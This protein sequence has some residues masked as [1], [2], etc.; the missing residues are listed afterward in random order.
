M[1]MDQEICRRLWKV[2]HA[3]VRRKNAT[4]PCATLDEQA[5]PQDQTACFPGRDEL[6]ET[7]IQASGQCCSFLPWTAQVLKAHLHRDLRWFDDAEVDE[8]TTI[9]GIMEENANRRTQLEER[10]VCDVHAH[11]CVRD[12]HSA[13]HCLKP[14]PKASRKKKTPHQ[15]CYSAG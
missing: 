9:N 3:H 13:T 11:T 12:V 1:K 15:N 4:H 7:E 10:G 5:K 8:K 14:P 6:A 2:Q